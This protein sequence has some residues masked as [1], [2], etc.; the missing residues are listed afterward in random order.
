MTY[1]GS[2][3]I[4]VCSVRNILSFLGRLC[5]HL[6]G[7]SDAV[8]VTTISAAIDVINIFVLRLNWH[9]QIMLINHEDCGLVLINSICC[10]VDHDAVNRLTD[11]LRSDITGLSLEIHRGDLFD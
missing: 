5:F 11:Y 8:E 7:L 4:F 1:L 3:A 10:V 6:A 9:V 2:P